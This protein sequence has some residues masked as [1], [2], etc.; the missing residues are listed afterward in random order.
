MFAS[1]DFSV[2]QMMAK[3]QQWKNED[4][5]TR[6]E[7]QLSA[8]HAVLIRMRMRLQFH[9]DGATTSD[10]R[11]LVLDVL[12]R[13]V[14][15][16]A[17]YS[18]DKADQLAEIAADSM[19]V[20]RSGSERLGV[21][22]FYQV[23]SNVHNDAVSSA[24]QCVAFNSL[25]LRVQILMLVPASSLAPLLFTGDQLRDGVTAKSTAASCT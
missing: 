7:A 14:L 15:A 8:M 18:L 22:D 10:Q 4:P 6:S 12:V 24:S 16:L 5:A 13:T 17:P 20:S 19:L 25:C 2:E 21:N 23:M 1:A 9:L 3:F 11:R